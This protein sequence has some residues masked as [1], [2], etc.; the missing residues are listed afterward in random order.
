MLLV[1]LLIILF[2]LLFHQDP[3]EAAHAHRIV[4]VA[5][6]HLAHQ[7][8]AGFPM[9]GLAI[10]AA[11]SH[12]AAPMGTFGEHYNMPHLWEHLGNIRGIFGEHYNMLRLWEYSGNIQGTF[13][14]HSVNIR[15][16]FG[17]HCNK[18]DQW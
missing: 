15:G 6:E 3:H 7:L 4:R 1:A 5:L 17:E 9:L 8:V 16:P 13:G 10:L 12:H 11:I 18:Q 14:E 2:P